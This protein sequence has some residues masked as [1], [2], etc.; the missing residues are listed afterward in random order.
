[1]KVIIGSSIGAL[2]F[3]DLL[4]RS[5]EIIWVKRPGKVGGLFGGIDSGSGILD[6]GMTNLELGSLQQKSDDREVES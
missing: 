5:E 4:S 6:I 2:V 3:A 1:M